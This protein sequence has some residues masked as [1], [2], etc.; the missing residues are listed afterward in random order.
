[1][2][3]PYSTPMFQLKLQEL[4]DA[5]AAVPAS[6]N[7]WMGT[8]MPEFSRYVAAANPVVVGELLRWA[9]ASGYGEADGDE[10]Y[11]KKKIARLEDK[12]ESAENEIELLQERLERLESEEC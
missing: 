9:E 5:L 10:E 2:T 3:I 6:D 11:Y 12:L 4:K 1:M 7:F 8:P